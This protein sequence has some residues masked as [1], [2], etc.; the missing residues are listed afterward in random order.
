[1]TATK[2]FDDIYFVGAYTELTALAEHLG[3]DISYHVDSDVVYPALVDT[4]GLWQVKSISRALPTHVVEKVSAPD[5]IITET[6]TVVLERGGGLLEGGRFLTRAIPDG[7][8]VIGIDIT[9]VESTGTPK[10]LPIK[11]YVTTPEGDPTPGVHF[12]VIRAIQ[13]T[14]GNSIP[15][16]FKATYKHGRFK[17]VKLLEDVPLLDSHDLRSVTLA[18]H[19]YKPF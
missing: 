16:W 13:C 17:A 5:P 14:D 3:E 7:H 1:M 6:T 9:S 15:M 4:R 12:S 18:I 8:H 2:V 11:C 10:E 19:T